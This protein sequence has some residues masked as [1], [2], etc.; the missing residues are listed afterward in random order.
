MI[1]SLAFRHGDFR[2][3]WLGA[4]CN[5]IGMNGEQVVISLLVYQI[6]GST[7]WVGVV[8]ALNFVPYAVFGGLSGAVADW[9]DRRI[10]LRRVELC[11]AANLLLFAALMGAGFADRWTILAFTLISGS[12]R[13]LH[14]PVRASYA[15]DIVGGEH[16]VSGIGLLNLGSRVGQLAGALVA[17]FATERLGAPAALLSLAFLH[18]GAYGL[19]AHL[20]TQ[21]L[22]TTIA[23]VPMGQNLREFLAEARSNRV[24]LML[25]VVTA[26]VEVF[27][28]SFATALP[29]LA[30]QRL[31]MG[32]EGLG[33]LHAARAVGGI[34]A[35]LL[36]S[37]LNRRGDGAM[38]TSASS[39]PSASVF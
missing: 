23:R 36:L 6:T 25:V 39:A 11:I 5:S 15:Y 20:R 28:F 27:G 32:A 9:M 2:R 22:A 1:R 35:T 4:T 29:E 8:L 31:A 21:G 24:L 38:S 14:Q 37:V 16:V 12:L 30:T 34:A 18:G 19:F 26:S 3:L 7:A 33:L 13:A 10:L 17:G